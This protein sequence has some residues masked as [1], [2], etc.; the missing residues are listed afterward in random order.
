MSMST[1]GRAIVKK[2]AVKFE[3][4]EIL[5]ADDF[6]IFAWYRNLWKTKPEKWNAIIQGIIS[7]DGCTE[8]CIK[9]RIN[10]WIKA[11]QT[12][13]IMLL[14]KHMGTSLLSFFSTLKC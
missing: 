8:N 7:K 11:L 3:G 14:L 4:N 12:N 5:I 10:A 6:D 9:L 13:Q 2:L 1:I